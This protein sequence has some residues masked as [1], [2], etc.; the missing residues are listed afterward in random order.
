MAFCAAIVLAVLTWQPAFSQDT[1]YWNTQY[2]PRSMLLSGAVI[3][4]VDDMSATY[5][6]PGA[7]GYIEKPE[8]LL[9]AN[10]YE[11]STLTIRDGG[12]DGLDLES[13]GF[14][15][16]PNMLAGAFRKS[17]LGKNKLAY[18]FLTRYRVDSEIRGARTDRVDVIER[19]PGEEDFG[20]GLKVFS[21]TSELWAGLTWSRGTGGWIGWGVTTYLSIRDLE[22]EN[23][24]FA[25]ALSDSGQMALYY[26]V[27]T[28]EG[29]NYSFLWKIGFGFNFYPLT[30]GLTLTTPNVQVSG[31]GRAAGN[32]SHI[33]IDV[34]GDG[35]VEDGFTA[36][37]Q[38]D[39]KANYNSPLSVGVGAG[40]N[41]EK[42]AIVASAE[43]FDAIDS[44]DVLELAPFISQETGE[45]RTPELKHKAKSIVNYGAGLEYQG[46]KYGGY[47]SFSTDFSSFED[48]SDIAVTGFDLYST[49]FGGTVAL[50]RTKFMLGL[51]YTWGSEMKEQIINLNPGD[52]SPVVDPDD[53]VEL[54][55]SRLTFMI[56]F[57]VNL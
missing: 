25:E 10:V 43:W 13:N 1:H 57:S 34:D 46:K 38:E 14:N 27:N 52:D 22:A 6:N 53:E 42:L 30:L 55:Y 18:S 35:A 4:S 7:L 37:V 54:V 56:G 36:S 19:W 50:N 49:N 17:W 11:L 32:I 23:R 15:L 47:L 41:F 21:K 29:R 39:V 48:E 5:Y 33:G 40:Y 24:L 51:G 8:L 16:L 31:Q 44:Y 9:S 45:L 2:G 20:G 3:G 12:G 26:D 28:Y